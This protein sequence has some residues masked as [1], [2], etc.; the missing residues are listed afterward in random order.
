MTAVLHSSH[1]PHPGTGHVSL[2]S[3]HPE[4]LLQFCF[5]VVT[6]PATD[7]FFD[8]A[9]VT[10]VCNT[11]ATNKLNPFF[12]TR[13]C[14]RRRRRR[15]RT[16]GHLY[17]SC[18]LSSSPS[19]IRPRCVSFLS[20]RACVCLLFLFVCFLIFLLSFFF[21]LCVFSLLTFT[22][23]FPFP[24]HQKKDRRKTDTQAHRKRQTDTDGEKEK[25]KMRK[26]SKK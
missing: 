12:G 22:C 5:R 20:L 10:F 16:T 14:V 13:S 17:P 4:F 6:S 9:N 26:Q 21:C 3:L 24:P 15:R 19:L 23:F 7:Q 1:A 2:L 18:I 8:F 11:F 25:N